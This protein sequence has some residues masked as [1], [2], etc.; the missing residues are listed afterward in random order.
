MSKQVAALERRLGAQ[1]MNRTSRELRPTPAGEDFYEAAVRVLSDLDD[2]ESRVSSGH[3]RPNGAVR[4][5]VPPML[6]AMMIVPKLSE[7]FERFPSISVEFIASERYAD[8]VQEGLDLAIRVGELD[9]SGQLTRKI[10]SMRIATLATPEYLRRNGPPLTPSDLNGHEILANRHMGA[11]SD[12][13]FSNAGG[14]SST[15]NGRWTSGLRNS[16]FAVPSK[17]G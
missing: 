6:T 4:V 14:T 12:W 11:V 7:F 3:G 17:P 8:L 2:A 16:L 9:S 5:A 10:G 13:L 15:G 1:L